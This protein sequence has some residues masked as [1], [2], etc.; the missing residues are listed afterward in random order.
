MI[1]ISIS[2]IFLIFKIFRV[3]KILWYKYRVLV[4]V[5][6]LINYRLEIRLFPTE[7]F[8]RQNE[9]VR[10]ISGIQ[11]N[12]YL[13]QTDCFVYTRMW[14]RPLRFCTIFQ[15]ILKTETCEELISRIKRLPHSGIT[16]FSR[17]NLFFFIVSANSDQSN[18]SILNH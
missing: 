8:N 17:T 16:A 3:F 13:L 14:M 6:K 9:V 7:V 11:G 2:C 4:C 18:A 5:I 1:G 12:S 10:E 15:S